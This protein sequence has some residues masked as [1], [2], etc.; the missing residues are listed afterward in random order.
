MID[1]LAH[2]IFRGRDAI[3][4]LTVVSPRAIVKTKAK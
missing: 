4:D 1:G 2:V 3:R